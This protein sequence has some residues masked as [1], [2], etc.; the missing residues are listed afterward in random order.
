MIVHITGCKAC[1]RLI[2]KWVWRSSSGFNDISFVKSEFNFTCNIFLGRF[3]ESTK[4]FTKWCEP[5]SFVYNLSEFVA[6]IFLNFHGST[7]DNQ[8]FK[9]F[10]SFHQDCSTRSFINTTGFHTNNTVLNDINDTDTML[11]AKFVEFAD[12]IR[13][14]HGFAVDCLR[15]T[16]FKC[17]SYIFIFIRCIFRC[18]SKNKKISVIW[19]AGWIFKFQ[20]FVADVP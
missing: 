10:V 14:L 1:Q 2:V 3:Y 11:A 15:N 8:F 7:V 5:F 17:H 13:N 16:F 18:I 6:K 9:L 20:S 12:D 19:F 4:S